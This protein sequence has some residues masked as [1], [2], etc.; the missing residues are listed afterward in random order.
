MT[1][2]REQRLEQ[3]GE[4]RVVRGGHFE[5]QP[6][7]LVVRAADLERQDFE[8]AAAFDHRVED[9]R[10]ELGVDQVAFGG[11]RGGGQ[12]CGHVRIIMRH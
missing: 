12:G 3:R 1:A 11:D 10:E 4:R 2:E 8:Q 5:G 6:R 9:P 7:E